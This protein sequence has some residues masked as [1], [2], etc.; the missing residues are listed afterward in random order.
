[1]AKKNRNDKEER[2]NEQTI[3]KTAAQQRIPLFA[4]G[5]VLLLVIIGVLVFRHLQTSSNNATY[6]NVVGEM[7]MLSQ[8]LAKASSLAVQGDNNAFTQLSDSHTKFGAYLNAVRFGGNIDGLEVHAAPDA[9]SSQIETLANQW[10]KLEKDASLLLNSRTKLVELSKNVDTIEKQNTNVLKESEN[11]TRLKI[12][13]GAGPKE[14][15]AVSNLSTLSQKMIKNALKLR[16]S[17]E[18]NPE[19]AYALGKDALNFDETLTDIQ[20]GNA[21]KGLIGTADAGSLR[22]IQILSALYKDFRGAV[23][24]IL[25]DMQPL[26]LAKQAGTRITNESET[27]LNNVDAL[28]NAI[29]SKLAGSGAT[30]LIL[31]FALSIGA[32]ALLGLLIYSYFMDSTRR[33]QEAED[34]RKRTFEESKVTQDAILRLMGELDDLANGDLTVTAT[35]SEDLTGTIADAINFTVEELRSLVHHINDA[36]VKLTQSTEIANASSAELLEA[37]KKQALE[38]K[39]AG[40]SVTKM[41]S[42]M[43]RVSNH[44]DRAVEVANQSMRAAEKGSNATHNSIQGM[45]EIRTQIQETSKRIKRLGE[46]SQE[47]GEIVELIS[48][49]TE[50]TNV[51]ALNAAIQAASAGD[52][53]RGF[54]VVAEEVQRLAERSGEATKQIATIVKTI[55]ADTQNAVSAMEQT[56]QG[57]LEGNR[58]AD[59]AGKSL[60]EIGRVST[61]LAHLIGNI[62][63]ATRNQSESATKVANQMKEI[64][65]VTE[66]TSEGTTRA[67][68]AVSELTDLASELKDSVAG[69]KVE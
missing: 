6:A 44:A 61:Q 37:S 66:K 45:N 26:R 63:K 5:F 43:V 41:S 28:S 59:E 17:D 54:S 56:T 25:E 4:T 1:M 23:N 32:V 30:Y 33:A 57:V 24:A 52:A 39:D 27:L 47:I 69:F 9:F 13:S 51:L 31:L 55:Q 40:E 49:I 20:K 50:Q 29:Q 21:S 65:N 67:S 35:V 36:T 42:S 68:Q 12:Q 7:R 8:R 22:Q 34:A 18:L 64:L 16:I 14:I 46:S 62:S 11:L 10:T 19:I 48:D 38:L 58:L 15:N 2:Q 53:G 60:E 3:Q